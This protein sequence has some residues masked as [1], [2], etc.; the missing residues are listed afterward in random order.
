MATISTGV[1]SPG[2]I[3]IASGGR[4]YAFNNLST[5]PAQ[6]LAA[7]PSRQTLTFHNPGTVDVFVAPTVVINSGSDVTLTP[8]VGSLG[9]CFRIYAN[10]GSLTLTGEVQKAWQAFSASASANPLTVVESN[11]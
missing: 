8:S 5:T 11:V 3:N 10:G 7:N 2:T 4:V 1:G 9:G 6:V